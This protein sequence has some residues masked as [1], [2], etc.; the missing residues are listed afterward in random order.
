[1]TDSWNGCNASMYL[2]TNL[3]RRL[4]HAGCLI[5]ANPWVPTMA[6][7]LRWDFEARFQDLEAGIRPAMR[8]QTRNA[9]SLSNETGEGSASVQ[10]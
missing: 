8:G 10:D 9:L 5:H 7:L 6:D 2:L 3:M 1:M 4:R